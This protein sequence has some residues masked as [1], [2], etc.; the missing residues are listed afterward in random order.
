M[1]CQRVL[2]SRHNSLRPNN[3]DDE[4]DGDDD[5]DDDNNNNNNINNN[6]KNSH[7]MHCPFNKKSKFL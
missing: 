7:G 5:D 4:D 6:N 1:N 2:L 3:D